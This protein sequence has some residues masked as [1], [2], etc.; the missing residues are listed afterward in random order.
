MDLIEQEL[1]SVE[2]VFIVSHH[3]ESLSIPVDTTIN[4]EKT[5]EGL[6]HIV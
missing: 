3:A 6:S 2:S 4:V 5:A 1:S